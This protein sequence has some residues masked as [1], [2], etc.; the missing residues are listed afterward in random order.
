MEQVT[1]VVLSDL[2][3]QQVSDDKSVRLI[4]RQHPDLDGARELDANAS[5]VEGLAAVAGDFVVLQIVQ[6]G[7]AGA[8]II[9]ALE[10]FEGLFADGVDPVDALDGAR[11]VGGSSNGGGKAKRDPAYLAQ[12]RTWANANGYEVAS[13][14]RIAGDIETAYNQAQAA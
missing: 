3:H 12:V 13:K 6:G 1:K 8:D 11:K 5:E 9:V 14:G 7:V 10:S 2:T 4:I